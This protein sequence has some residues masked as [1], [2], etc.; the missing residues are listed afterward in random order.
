MIDLGRFPDAAATIAQLF[1]R[2]HIVLAHS[3]RTTSDGDD[4]LSP[5]PRTT[6]FAQQRTVS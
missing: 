1:A 6:R 5:A 4:P 3:R 2:A